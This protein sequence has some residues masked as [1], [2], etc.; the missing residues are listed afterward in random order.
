MDKKRLEQLQKDM[1]FLGKEVI[2]F[3]RE[4]VPRL[5]KKTYADKLKGKN[6]IY[7]LG[8]AAS[9]SAI[10]FHTIKCLKTY[11]LE[12][13]HWISS[14]AGF[15]VQLNGTRLLVDP[16]PFVLQQIHDGNIDPRLIDAVLISHHHADHNVE[17]ALMNV[18]SA[19]GKRNTDFELI[20]DKTAIEGFRYNTS[21]ATT[22]VVPEPLDLFHEKMLKGGKGIVLSPGKKH[23]VKN[24]E[25]TAAPATDVELKYKGKSVAYSIGFRFKTNSLTIGYFA[26]STPF[27]LSEEYRY[28]YHPTKEKSIESIPELNKSLVM[29][30]GNC[31]VLIINMNSIFDSLRPYRKMGIDGAREVLLYLKSIKQEPKLAILHHWGYNTGLTTPKIKKI[32]KREKCRNVREFAAKY[33]QEVTGIRTVASHDLSLLQILGKSKYK[34]HHEY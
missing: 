19:A 24:I 7:F 3:D 9:G 23:R 8:S 14:V 2:R 18:I 27:K 1:A 13:D 20:G 30:Y 17:Q 32:L 6:C 31:D 21:R 33:I 26:D 29:K 22:I 10:A 5:L 16:G 11:S 4:D 15:I 25:I 12:N 28:A 34:W